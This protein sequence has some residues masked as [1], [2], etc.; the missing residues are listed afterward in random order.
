[1]STVTQT[2]PPRRAMKCG[3]CEAEWSVPVTERPGSAVHCPYCEAHICACGCGADLSEQ[4]SDAVYQSEAHGKKLQRLRSTD[5]APTK[6]VAEARALHEDAK[7]HW[8]M[9]VDEAIVR[10]FKAD[11]SRIF[12]ADDLEP[13][14]IPDEHR[15]V[16]GSQ[17]A[18]WV[19][20]KRMVECGRRASVVASRNGA[21]S[22]EYRLTERGARLVAG[23]DTPNPEGSAAEVESESGA[24]PSTGRRA[25]Y[26]AVPHGAGSS[27]SVG[28][29]EG[30]AEDRGQAG[31]SMGRPAD[32]VR[33]DAPPDHVHDGVLP[34]SSPYSSENPF[35]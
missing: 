21:K 6:P 18:K 19:N 13:I 22:N 30:G 33:G 28:S 12:H 35:A 27:G 34:S 29:G 2:R 15:N 9:V 5:I 26:G 32:A 11:P 16:I 25:V 17:I 23:P 24:A 7:A 14:G 8:S 20:R 10:H 3:R 1:V 31:K 4:R